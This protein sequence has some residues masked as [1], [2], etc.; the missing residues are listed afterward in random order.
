MKLLVSTSPEADA[1]RIASGLLSE[2]LVACVNLL[3]G[4]KSRYWW[5]GRLEEADEVV[6]LMKTRD[7]LVERAIA[8]LVELHP[9]EVPEAVTVDVSGGLAA[10]LGWVEE[11]T[12]GRPGQGHSVLPGQQNGCTAKAPRT[13]RDT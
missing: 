9:Y 13:P 3:R 12:G 7:D 5:K 2:R 4:V 1:D 10:Y 8:R 6:M 11:V